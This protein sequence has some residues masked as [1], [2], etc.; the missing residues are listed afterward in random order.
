MTVDPRPVIRV[1]QPNVAQVR[2]PSRRV[3]EITKLY[4][5]D[6]LRHKYRPRTGLPIELEQ[7]CISRAE[8][9][10]VIRW[11]EGWDRFWYFLLL[12]VSV[13]AAVAAVAAI[14]PAGS[15]VWPFT[16]PNRTPPRSVS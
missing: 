3:R 16:G 5:T 11:R 2:F 14:W 12:G 6:E 13:V 8:L 15:A 9:E 7:G 10:A 4:T 1:R